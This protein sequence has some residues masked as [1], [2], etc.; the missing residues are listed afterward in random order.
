MNAMLFRSI[1]FL[2]EIYAKWEHVNK[3]DIY[4]QKTYLV[5]MYFF[6]R[7]TATNNT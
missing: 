3:K 7:V 6:P 1:L 5:F 2:L 4:P